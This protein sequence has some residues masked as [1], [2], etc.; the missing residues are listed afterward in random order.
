MVIFVLFLEFLFWPHFE[1]VF[2][3]INWNQL[4]WKLLIDKTAFVNAFLCNVEFLWKILKVL[5]KCIIDEN[6][7][8]QLT[9]MSW[10]GVSIIYLKMY[11]ASQFINLFSRSFSQTLIMTSIIILW[12]KEFQ[13]S[14]TLNFSLQVLLM[15]W[16][17]SELYRKKEKKVKNNQNNLTVSFK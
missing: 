5:T 8:R 9:F 12:N 16:K 6:N 1:R 2:K 13:L 15:D 17:E 14:N 3:E 11:Q 10:P 4:Q 7:N